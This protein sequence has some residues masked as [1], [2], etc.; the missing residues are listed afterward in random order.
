MLKHDMH[1]TWPVYSQPEER[2]IVKDGMMLVV[3]RARTCLGANGD[4]IPMTATL[5]PDIP[6]SVRSFELALVQKIIY[7]NYGTPQ[8]T[9]KGQVTAPPP[10]RS[11]IISEQKRTV[12]VRIQPGMHNSCE[13]NC[14][15][16]PSYNAM[17]VSTARLIENSYEVHVSAVL[18]GGNT[19]TVGL[20]IIV[21][22]FPV[23][24]SLELMQ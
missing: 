5:Y 14:M 1:S 16:P 17:T 24:Y 15:L 10:P 8:T 13:L 11:A 20:P 18:E 4:Q 9:R 12:N 2:K 22:P 3:S 7:P 21:S 23:A 6:V 19:I